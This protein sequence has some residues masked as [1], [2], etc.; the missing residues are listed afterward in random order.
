MQLSQKHLNQLR[1]FIRQEVAKIN[2]LEDLEELSTTASAGG[3]YQTP[4]AFRKKEKDDDDLK[5]SKGMSVVKEATYWEFRNNPDL[6]SKQKLA[7]SMS[8]IREALSMIERS[9]KY[10]VKLKKETKMGSSD[11]YK[12]TKVA[13]QKISEKLVRL[14]HKVKDLS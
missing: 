13:L 8:N 7:K 1:K 10:N 3:Q 2:E 6:S 4:Y 11:Y 5:L 14:S 9:I 12:R